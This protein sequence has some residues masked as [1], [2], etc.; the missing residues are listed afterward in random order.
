VV[1][2]FSPES[3]SSTTIVFP[4]SSP[5]SSISADATFAPDE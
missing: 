2:Y 4:R 5:R 1:R 3:H